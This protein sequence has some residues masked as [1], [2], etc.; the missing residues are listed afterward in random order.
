[1]FNAGTGE[2]TGT[3]T[4]AGPYDFVVNVTDSS[5]DPERFSTVI[6]LNVVSVGNS[7]SA[8]SSTTST[9]KPPNISGKVTVK[10]GSS[11]SVQPEASAS[12]K[13][14]GQVGIDGSIT[15]TV[16]CGA[17]GQPAAAPK[18]TVAA[19]ST[20]SGAKGTPVVVGGAGF[21]GIQQVFFGTT[22][23]ISFKVVSPNQID[24]K[25]PAGK[26]TVYIIIEGRK[27]KSA[28]ASAARFTYKGSGTVAT[29]EQT[30]TAN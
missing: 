21:T 4:K 14:G 12:Y 28:E 10:C 17:N 26:G 22:P 24:A 2:V 6:Y 23:A 3:P 11:V 16:P 1:M 27:G 18:P 13:V 5:H 20:P 25:A 15:V 29:V 8:P 7:T 30:A 19:T 9:T